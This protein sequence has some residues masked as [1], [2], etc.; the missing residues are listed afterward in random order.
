[1]LSSPSDDT[2]SDADIINHKTKEDLELPNSFYQI[3]LVGDISHE[4]SLGGC[5][6]TLRKALALQDRIHGNL[7]KLTW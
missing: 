5:R 7:G 2:S 3:G 4:V 6:S 1:M